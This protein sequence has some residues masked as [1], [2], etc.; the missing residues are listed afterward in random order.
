MRFK[1]EQ[2]GAA[3]CLLENNSIEKDKSPFANTQPGR[4]PYNSPI[5]AVWVL[6]P[7]NNTVEDRQAKE[8]IAFPRCSKKWGHGGCQG[9]GHYTP[10]E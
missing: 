10:E 4:C 5:S 2:C 8:M 3:P 9:C 7:T 6:L 1:C